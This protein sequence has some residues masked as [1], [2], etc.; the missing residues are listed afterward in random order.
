MINIMNIFVGRSLVAPWIVLGEES[1][2]GYYYWG[3]E[4]ILL[5]AAAQ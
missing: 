1:V 2:F 4:E 3:L 5:S